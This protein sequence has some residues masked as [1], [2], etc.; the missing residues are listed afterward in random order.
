M[1]VLEGG[2]W[3]IAQYNLTVPV[4]NAMLADVAAKIR[5]HTK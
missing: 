2:R 1:L 4:P 3:L 5:E